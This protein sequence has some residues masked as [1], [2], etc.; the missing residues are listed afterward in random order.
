MKDKWVGDWEVKAAGAKRQGLGHR[1][2]SHVCV[3]L[4][5]KGKLSGK[6]ARYIGLL[7]CL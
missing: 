3:A 1:Y 6:A 5:G 7:P 2:L 4:A